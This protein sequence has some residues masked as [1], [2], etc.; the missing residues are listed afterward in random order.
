M[1]DAFGLH[2]IKHKA[3]A[4][5]RVWPTL[6]K[7]K[8]EINSYTAAYYIYVLASTSGIKEIYDK[9]IAERLWAAAWDSKSHLDASAIIHLGEQITNGGEVTG[10]PL[11][12]GKRLKE[13]RISQRTGIMASVYERTDVYAHH[14]F[15]F[16]R[17]TE[18]DY[19]VETF[20]VLRPTFFKQLQPL[21]PHQEEP[22]WSE[23]EDNE[24]YDN[25]DNL[26]GIRTGNEV[27]DST[28]KVVAV[29]DGYRLIRK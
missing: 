24:I 10:H 13:I 27:I 7:G 14:E 2:E 6:S 5:R 21:F 18:F 23:A 28:G 9:T 3:E 22:E 12:A 1:V 26:V 16:G 11:L 25:E 19:H 4:I 29:I 20:T 17:F 8:E 15:L